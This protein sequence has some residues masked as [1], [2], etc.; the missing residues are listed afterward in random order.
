VVFLFVW[1]LDNL[2]YAVSYLFTLENISSK[3]RKL[4]SFTLNE[5]SRHLIFLRVSQEPIVNA[6]VPSK[7]LI[8]SFFSLAILSPLYS[9]SSVSVKKRSV[10]YILQVFTRQTAEKAYDLDISLQSWS[11]KLSAAE[12]SHLVLRFLH[13]NS[14]SFS[15]SS[16][17]F[18]KVFL[19]SKF[20][21]NRTFSSA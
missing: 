21:L 8:L 1:Y 12:I 7:R 6:E 14:D 15:H 11:M 9:N 3:S 10:S 17:N 4:G 16:L 13:K 18:I 19:V 20:L 2:L 5:S